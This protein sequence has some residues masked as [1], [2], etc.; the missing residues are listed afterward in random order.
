MKKSND[1]FQIHSFKSCHFDLF[2]QLEA[3][4][5]MRQCELSSLENSNVATFLF[6]EGMDEH[7]IKS[8]AAILDDVESVLEKATDEL[9]QHL[10][11]LK[12]SEKWV[13]HSAQFFCR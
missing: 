3:F 6:V 12:H 2:L 4:V 7:T 1:F 11:Q 9:L 10:H 13:G 8:I 5:K